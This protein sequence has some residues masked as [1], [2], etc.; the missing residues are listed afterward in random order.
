MGMAWAQEIL[1][2][3]QFA[4]YIIRVSG[5][6]ED[7]MTKTTSVRTAP[8]NRKQWQTPEVARIAADSAES[9]PIPVV[10]D[11]FFSMGS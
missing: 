2:F 10:A 8:A 9:S 6:R 3:D 5:H 4:R 1:R 7:S 11:G